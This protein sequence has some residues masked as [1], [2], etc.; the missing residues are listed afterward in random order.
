MIDG[1]SGRYQLVLLITGSHSYLTGRDPA[2]EAA[3]I[4]QLR[5][6]GQAGQQHAERL[7]GNGHDLD[8]QPVILTGEE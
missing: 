7:S 1:V 5:G 2:R 4:V 6:V 3:G 8:R